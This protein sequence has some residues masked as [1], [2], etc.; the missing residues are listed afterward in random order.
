MGRG[1]GSQLQQRKNPHLSTH[2]AEFSDGVDV[3]PEI[4]MI[5]VQK[6]KMRDN[7]KTKAVIR[8]T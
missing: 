1:Q 2:A 5:A 6:E 4:Q 8:K 7:G 3:K